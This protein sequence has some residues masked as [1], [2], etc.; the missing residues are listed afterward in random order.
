MKKSAKRM[1][2]LLPALQAVVSNIADAKQAWLGQWE[3]GTVRLAAAIAGKVIR[4]RVDQFAGSDA[5]FGARSAGNGSR[6]FASANSFEPD[7]P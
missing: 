3:R 1:Q 6:Q 2:T 5:D 7:R 4:G